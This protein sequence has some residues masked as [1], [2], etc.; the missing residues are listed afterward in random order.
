M[1]KPH[2]KG[3]L[4]ILKHCPHL[5]IKYLGDSVDDIIAGNS[6][7]VETIG[8][9]SPGADYNIMKNNFR[10][11]G[12]KYMLDDVKN[13]ESFLDEIGKNYVKES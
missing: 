11:L 7:N 10:H 5:S 9:V 12:A 8:I 3:V 1:L 6:A 4:N 13:I 2:P